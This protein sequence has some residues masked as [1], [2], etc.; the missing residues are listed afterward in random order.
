MT[1]NARVYMTPSM[2]VDL[3]NLKR[4]KAAIKDWEAY[5]LEMEGKLLDAVKDQGVTLPDSGSVELGDDALIVCMLRRDWVQGCLAEFVERHPDQVGS[6]LVKEWKPVS[7]E[8]VDAFMA[9]HHPGAEELKSCFTE[10]SQ[11]PSF[12]IK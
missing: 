11:K 2:M 5:Q 7:K 12:R 8:K 1:A 3:E 10:K 9:S 6:I 4:A